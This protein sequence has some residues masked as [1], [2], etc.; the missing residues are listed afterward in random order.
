[1]TSFF[2]FFTKI[3]SRLQLFVY[4][5]LNGQFVISHFIVFY[6]LFP[7]YNIYR[8]IVFQFNIKVVIGLF[9]VNLFLWG[10]FQ[11]F[12]TFYIKIVNLIFH[13]SILNYRVYITFG[14]IL[15]KKF[16]RFFG[17]YLFFSISSFYMM[18]IDSTNI[19][20][21]SFYFFS[22]VFR[23]VFMLPGLGYSLILKINRVQSQ[24]LNITD[25]VEIFRTLDGGFDMRLILFRDVGLHLNSDFR[26]RFWGWVVWIHT[27]KPSLD[28]LKKTSFV[29]F[30]T[31]CLWYSLVIFYN[32]FF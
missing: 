27:V 8:A 10:L 7:L 3:L 25:T 16:P 11:L 19:W 20:I 21:H 32:S 2:S 24:Y 18:K 4:L 14:T 17:L 28:A 5:K 1:M 15:V 29:S 12:K 30:L 9:M 13:K 26:F 22:V 23:N 31:T 6:F